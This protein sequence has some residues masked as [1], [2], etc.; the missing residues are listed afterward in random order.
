MFAGLCL[1]HGRRPETGF[2]QDI[3]TALLRS[4][5]I[6]AETR[7]FSRTAERIGRSQSA[8]STQI[9]KLEE[10]L[11]CTLFDRDRRNVRLTEEG[12]KLLGYASQILRLSE[13]MIHRFREPD[14]AG[15]VRF[16]SP[17]DFA[18]FYLPEILA[19]FSES[20]PRVL[21]HVNCD[22][23]LRLI[24]GFEG[25]QYDLIIIK[26]DPDRL[27]PGSRPLWRERLV[28]VGGPACTPA[29]GFA[30]ACR[31]FGHRAHPVPL[32]LSP[33][34]CVYRQRAVTALDAAQAPWTV[35]YS[36]PSLA[37]ATAAV[38]AGLGFSVLP[39]N[40]V[41]KELVAFEGGDGWPALGDAAICV[42]ASERLDAAA[43]ALSEF[44]ESHVAS[45]R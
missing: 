32:V 33:S 35:A 24:D 41:P 1:N 22:L 9:Q 19:S 3:D 5:T 40:M 2:M 7:S 15:E 30:D 14:V 21:L 38:K 6:L 18:T 12:E 29:M 45:Y 26:Q 11:G 34:P 27:Y 37:G 36:S 16:G 43:T 39:R 4:F 10:M 25:D 20:F 44:I 42:L 8:V 28:W 17:E 31:G 23:T 13:A